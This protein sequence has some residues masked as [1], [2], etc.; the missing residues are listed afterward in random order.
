MPSRDTRGAGDARW[1][2]S[3]ARV[4][5]A[6]L[7][8]DSQRRGS[9]PWQGAREAES[10]RDTGT[11]RGAIS[12]HVPQ[13]DTHTVVDFKR[14]SGQSLEPGELGEFRWL[15]RLG[16]LGRFSTVTGLLHTHDNWL[17]HRREDHLSQR[18]SGSVRNSD[19]GVS[20]AH[21]PGPRHRDLSP[22]GE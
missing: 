21:A 10:D 19:E 8:G 7:A 2:P 22:A 9:G 12:E 20:D 18:E 1:R 6:A 14:T 17:Q 13:P 16:W 5:S 4:L 3:L 11:K 15:G